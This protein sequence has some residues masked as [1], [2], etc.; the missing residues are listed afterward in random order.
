M[1]YL[2]FLLGAG[3]FALFAILMKEGD[4]IQDDLIRKPNDD[5]LQESQADDDYFTAV[6]KAREERDGK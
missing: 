2:Y 3:A 5:D 4:K 1:E 6:I